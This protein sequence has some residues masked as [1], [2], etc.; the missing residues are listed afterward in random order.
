MNL[1]FDPL[2]NDTGVEI[3]DPIERRRYKLITDTDVDIKP[4]ST[5]ELHFPVDKAVQIETESITLPH[6]V[7]TYIR[8]TEGEMLDSL[9]HFAYQEFQEEEEYIVELTAPIK[10]YLKVVGSLTMSA[11][12][13]QMYFTFG[14]QT[15][16]FIGARSH[17]EKPAATITTSQD[18]NDVMCAIS[19]LS[20]ALKT[21]NCERSYPTLRGHP[22]TIELGEKLDIPDSLTKPDTGIEIEVPTDYSSIFVVAPLAYY[23]GADVVPGNHPKIT[24][25]T[26]F[27]YHLGASRNFEAVVERVLKQVFFLDCITRTEGYYQ[28]HLHERSKIESRVN[29]DF[30]SLYNKEIGEQIEEYLSIPFETIQD[31]LPE[32]K[33]STHITPSSQNIETIPFV[34]NDLAVVHTPSAKRVSTSEAQVAA[35]DEFMRADDFTRSAS[36]LSSNSLQLVKPETTDSL[37]QAW[38]GD[39]APLQASKATAEAFR[40]KLSRTPTSGEIEITVVCN[41]EEMNEEREV[42][43]DVYGSHE[44]L[45]FEVNMHHDLT[46]TELREIF[47]SDNDFLHYVGHIDENGFKCKDGVFDANSL[48]SV[49]I[50]AFL[51]NACQSYEQG[52]SL[53]DAGS[54]GGIVTLS[55]VINSGAVEIGCNIARLLNRGFPLRAA[56]TIA[57]DQTIVGGQYTVVGDGNVDIAQSESG[58]PL[59]FDIE[60]EDEEYVVEIN[61]YPAS[62]RD[63]GSIISPNIKENDEYFLNSGKLKKF[64]VSK[65]KLEEFLGLENVPLRIDGEFTWSEDV[66]LN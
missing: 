36:D 4:S 32:W 60:F 49:G 65:E 14:E 26:G 10:I 53:I 39:D 38:I 28:V 19:Y 66:S 63:M 18:P 20:S 50:D 56:L 16:V 25:K 17:H 52:M 64:Y 30:R 33:L 42:V 29:L 44:D 11:D 59:L 9:D 51:L 24:T 15:K 34:V 27:E 55:D 37:E 47:I 61:T 31:L 62:D 22:P 41:D 48:D 40:N 35:I 57:Q 6:V 3:T 12:G 5:D 21:T 23:L 8:N 45:P 58:T 54:V 43:N 7:G 13:E 1:S 2:E 46:T